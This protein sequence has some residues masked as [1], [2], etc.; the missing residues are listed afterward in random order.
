MTKD[1]YQTLLYR[2]EASLYLDDLVALVVNSALAFDLRLFSREI[3]ELTPGFAFSLSHA[4]ELKDLTKKKLDEYKKHRITEVD[5]MEYMDQARKIIRNEN[6]KTGGDLM[7]IIN[8]I[9]NGKE[10][11]K[12]ESIQALEQSYRDVCKKILDCQETIDSAVAAAKGNPPTS[13]IY[14][15]NERKFQIAKDQLSLL[16]KQEM[17]LS[18]AIAQIDRLRLLTDFNR[19]QEQIKTAMKVVLG[20]QKFQ[21]LIQAKAELVDSSVDQILEKNDDFGNSILQ[22][23][24]EATSKPATQ[25]EFGAAV[26]TALR[27]DD[28]MKMAGAAEP[29]PDPAQAAGEFESRVNNQDDSQK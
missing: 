27:H 17:Q 1:D 29:T 9:F 22:R 18:K 16:N 21:D 5:L 6:L 19:M 24:E 2:N 23:A 3:M 26:A 12:Q 4:R 7:G 28:L 14:R 13:F 11:K 8:R 15:D 25:N 20:D 10:I